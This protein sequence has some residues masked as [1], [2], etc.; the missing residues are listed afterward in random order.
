MEHYECDGCGACCRTFPIFASEA[1]VGRESRIAAEGKPLAEHLASPEWL[2]QLYPLPFLETCCFLNDAARCEIYD[3]RPEVCR[4]F[5]AG[6][7]Q[8]QE[9]RER[10]RISPLR[11]AEGCR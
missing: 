3:T 7:P 5:A 9:A 10:Q 11:P 6:S 4:Q 2:V 1:D 8:C